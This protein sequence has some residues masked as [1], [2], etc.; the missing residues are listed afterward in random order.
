[1]MQLDFV[2][3]GAAKSGTTTLHD[4]LIQHPELCI[5]AEKDF[6]Y[7]DNDVN[8]EKG[9]NWYKSYFDSC[10]DSGKR[11]EIAATYLYSKAAA[12]RLAND[13]GSDLKIIALLRNPAHRAYS[14][15]MHLKRSHVEL[16]LNAYYNKHKTIDLQMPHYNEIIDRGFYAR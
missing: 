16:D 4:I 2:N 15:Y 8:Y 14:E 3:I 12:A 13:V 11:G 6:H 9:S 5:P 7:F 1:M 10:K